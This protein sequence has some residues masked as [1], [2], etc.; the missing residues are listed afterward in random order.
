MKN[1]N[2]ASELKVD[3][4]K[5]KFMTYDDGNS[6]SGTTADNKIINAVY[7]YNGTT[8][9]DKV[10]GS[11]LASGV[12]TFDGFNV[13]I[14]RNGTQRFTVKLD[15]VDDSTKAN[16]TIKTSIVAYSVEDED[17]DDVFVS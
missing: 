10:S 17:G 12:A 9:L 15:V 4:L 14:A 5:V 8:L 11:N 6:A 3:E 13:K 2:D 7:L 1:D 16:D